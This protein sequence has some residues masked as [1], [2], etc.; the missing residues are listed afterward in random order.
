[1]PPEPGTTPVVLRVAVG[2]YD[3]VEPLLT[4]KIALRGVTLRAVR[5]PA[6]QIF[7][8]AFTTA[9]WDL[10]ELSMALYTSM[11]AHG[12]DRYVGLPVFLSRR[13]RHSAV[14]VA[15]DSPLERLEELRGRRVGVP[16]WS[17]TACIYVRGVLEDRH[18]VPLTSVS[19]VE[20]TVDDTARTEHL[21]VRLPAG[22]EL[23]KADHEP[24][25][26]MLR[27]GRLDA[28]ISASPPKGVRSGVARSLLRSPRL[29]ETAYFEE[30][31]VHP[32]M[33][34]LVLRRS[35]HEQHPWLAAN[36]VAGFH[37]A[38]E[39]SLERL[40]SK[41]ASLYP[42]PHLAEAVATSVRRFGGD[43][44]PYGLRSN[45]PTIA[46]FCEHAWR[47]G[48]VH[49][50]VEPEELFPVIAEVPSPSAD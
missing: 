7:D 11:V 26:V 18:R 30:T 50:Y 48:V 17:Q 6:H 29:E 9:E 27:E 31:G 32:I 24:L 22:V 19:W 1:M 3:H 34:V 40:G 42:V 15:S 8:R 25:S 45:R 28:I 13:F 16:K 37:A 10:C 46:A 35:V 41:G 21:D 49:R 14:F 43:P 33:H 38:K 5:L 47:Q 39:R 23:R 12:D 4:G 44:F 2:E 20:G 36:L